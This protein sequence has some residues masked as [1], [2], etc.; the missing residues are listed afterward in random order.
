MVLNIFSRVKKSI[1]TGLN[2]SGKSKGQSLSAFGLLSSM[3]G[4]SGRITLAS[5]KYYFQETGKDDFIEFV[6]NPL[7]I[8]SALNAES[9]SATDQVEEE[10]GG[11][12]NLTRLKQ[13][14]IVNLDDQ[15][16]KQSGPGSS[17]PY[18]I[19]PL[20]KK[21]DAD[22]PVDSFTIGR[23]KEN[24]MTMKAMAISKLHAVIHISNG[25][26]YIKDCGSTNGS[27]LND[28]SITD[29]PVKLNDKDIVSLAN[30]NF[31]YLTPASLHDLLGKS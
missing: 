24:D 22:S 18:A 5:L 6:Q 11:S 14:H 4:P 25:A 13:T 19:Y 23:T 8:G 21:T 3:L 12:S 10:P 31:T 16:S 20:V 9:I 15:I 7:L 1:N 30:F 2:S 27:T 28:Q 29:K 26:F 17:L